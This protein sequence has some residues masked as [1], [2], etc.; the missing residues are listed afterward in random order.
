[1][2]RTLAAVAP[3]VA[4]V[5]LYLVVRKLLL[6][7]ATV[8]LLGR[9]GADPLMGHGRTLTM[10]LATMATLV[11]GALLQCLVPVGLSLDPAV[12]FRESF[13]DPFVLLGWAS[14]AGL[15][16]AALWPGPSARL[17]RIGVAFAWVIALPWIIVPLNAPMAEHRLY[18]PL[19][20]LA[21]IAVALAPRALATL[22]T[23]IGSPGRQ[24][25]AFAVLAVLGMLGSASRSWLYRDERE[26][27]RHELAQNPN[28]F[29][30]WWGLGTA[31][32]RHG[33]VVGAAPALANAHAIYPGHYDV[34]RNYTEVLVSLPDDVAE[35]HRALAIAERLQTRGPE[36]PWGRTLLAQAHLQAGRTTGDVEHFAEAERIALSCLEIAEPKG[37]V[38]QLAAQARSGLGDDDG[39]LAHLDTSIERGFATIGVR[40]DRALM[41]R[42]LGRLREARRDLSAVQREAPTDARVMYALLQ[43]ASPPK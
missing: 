22:R 6:G 10:Q 1:V 9:T 38:W 30:G 15:T 8:Q 32:W 11:P 28:S 26:L 23:R 5:V 34:L 19:V 42:R 36:D 31:C 41:L 37:Y 25:A 43:F 27:W 24:R 12:R 33:D 17:R 20:G 35:P 40:I 16:V 39:A 2:R 18:A 21:A 14:V 3:V 4:V 29:R 7:Q 13:A